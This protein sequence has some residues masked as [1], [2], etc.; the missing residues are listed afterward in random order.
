MIHRREFLRQVS[1]GALGAAALGDAA[2]NSTPASLS[3]A[4]SGSPAFS[5]IPVVGDGRW[6]WTQPPA[7]GTGFLEPRSYDLDV[8]IEMEG[9]GSATEIISTTT[10][11]LA[12]PEQKV[13][14]VDVETVGCEAQL[15]ELAPGAGQLLLMAEG[16]ERGQ[17]IKAVAHY[18]LTLFKQY[19]GYQ[20][21]QFPEKQ[22]PPADVRMAYLQDSPGI[23][24]KI[25]PLR[26]LAA[27]LSR[28]SKHPWDRAQA[29]ADWVPKNI[30]P[31]IGSYTSVSAA[32]ETR[33][34][35]CE[36]MAGV[37][38]ALCRAVNIPARLVWIPNHTWAEFYLVDSQ[39]RGHWIPAH[40]A[41]Y[42]WFGWNG[43]HE[44]VL[45]KGDRVQVPERHKQMRLLEDWTRYA[46]RRPT[47]RYT[48][49]L[50]PLADSEGGDPGPGARRK[51]E[52]GEWKV[53]GEHTLNRYVRR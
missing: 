40:T 24:T 25:K 52:K 35:D 15:R 50:K 9:I 10:V 34:G 3:N 46:G 31:Q 38:V 20:R 6:I 37:F 39:K 12:H 53:V 5:V 23:Q 11:P 7:E 41:C 42:P 51:D 47:I 44:L 16:I 48:A 22:E 19:F 1:H 43:V 4:P 18:R 21:D 8:G 13:E 33:R 49:D 28:G 45:Q 26:D 14:S 29:F 17:Q 27:E 32:L 30:R 2:L 36:E